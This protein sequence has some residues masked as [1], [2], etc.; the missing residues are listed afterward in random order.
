MQLQCPGKC[1]SRRSLTAV[2]AG[3]DSKLLFIEDTLLGWRLLVDLGAQHSIWS[4]STVD[5][6]AGGQG[7]LMD[8]ANGTPIRTYST[9]HV[10]ACFSGLHFG[11]DFVM[12]SSVLSA[13]WWTSQGPR[14]FLVDLGG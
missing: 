6:M 2:S 13:C 12:T 8:T 11:W 10:E 3:A 9:R 7:S 14:N 4:E 5:T 1:Q